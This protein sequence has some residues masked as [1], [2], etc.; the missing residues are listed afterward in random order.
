MDAT[1]SFGASATGRAS[2]GRSLKLSPKG[3]YA[4]LYLG[5]YLIEEKAGGGEGGG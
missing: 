5:E 1:P 2:G 4:G 3:V